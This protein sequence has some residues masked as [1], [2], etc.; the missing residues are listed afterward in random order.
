[1]VPL[2]TVTVASALVA[3]VLGVRGMRRVGRV[4]LV[5]EA[6]M[7]VAMVDVHLPA[8][9]VVPA[10]FWA[11]LLGACALGTALVDR[12]HRAARPDA[13][14]LHALGMLLGAAFVLLDGDGLHEAPIPGDPHGHAVVA[15]LPLAVAVL[16]HVGI[17]VR[18]LTGRR[19]GRPEV[20]RRACSLVSVLA[21]GAMVVV[22]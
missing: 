7:L 10:P 15:L 8:L 17:V 18:D 21:M 14:H 16:V 13:D 1:M 5:A 2:L 11:L 4:P 12:L 3:L 20:L 9:G 19:L 22:H 6:V